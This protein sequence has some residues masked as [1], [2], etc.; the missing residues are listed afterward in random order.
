VA[1]LDPPKETATAA[2]KELQGHGVSVKVVT[3]DNDLV[4]RKICTEVGLATEF[5][6]LGDEVEKLTEEQLADAAEKAT[7]EA[8]TNRRWLYGITIAI[9]VGFLSNLVAIL[10]V[11]VQHLHF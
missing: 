10:V 6:L 2:I 7:Q 8:R 5:V 9:A 3:G 4:A 11:A 1:F